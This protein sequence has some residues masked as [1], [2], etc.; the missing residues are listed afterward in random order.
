MGIP[1]IFFQTSKTPINL[2]VK[3][4]IESQLTNDW[5]YLWFSD[6]DILNFFIENPLP[7]FPNIIEKYN[8][9]TN[10]AH[11]ADL[12]RYYF[13]YINGG[14]FMDS[15]A[16]LYDNIDS[17]IKDYDFVSVESSVHPGKIFQGILGCIPK[18]TIMFNA[19]KHAYN[20]NNG[21]LLNDYHLLC[22]ELYTIL[23]QTDNYNIYLLNERRINNM[24]DEIFDTANKVVF[25][26]YWR[27]KV[28]PL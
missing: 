19:L 8:S 15:D 24:H 14:F 3:Q 25:K 6:N 12:F 1:K 17:I 22:G 2:Y 4:L 28:I 27:T 18:C 21:N 20:T 23:K 10:G 11:R 16:M 26:H 13:L 7:E 9:F 5:R